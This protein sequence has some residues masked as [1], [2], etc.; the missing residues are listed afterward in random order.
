MG[1][2]KGIPGLSF[3]WKRAT[4]LSNAKRQLSRQLGV[5]LTKAGR[6]RKIGKALGCCVPTAF[7]VVGLSAVLSIAG[8]AHHYTGATFADPYGFFSGIWHGIVWPL[9]LLAN[10][11]SWVLS[12]VG[13]SFLS[14]I[15]LIG[16]PNS[17]LFYYIG[18]AIGLS[19]AAGGG[20]SASST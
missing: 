8:C 2:K 11:V 18:F 16:R 9:A 12:L 5:P 15:Q 3:S 4:G 14:D 17:G 13:I 1:R 20:S 19:A 7:L 6:Q 10:I